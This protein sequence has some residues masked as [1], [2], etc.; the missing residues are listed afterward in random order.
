MSQATDNI[1]IHISLKI[2]QI[3]NNNTKINSWV[4]NRKKKWPRL[5]QN[6][7]LEICKR[8]FLLDHTPLCPGDMCTVL[9]ST[10][11]SVCVCYNMLSLTYPHM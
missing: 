4:K 8:G 11:V 6:S 9:F 5:K 10:F 2:N 3:I 7:T 1:H